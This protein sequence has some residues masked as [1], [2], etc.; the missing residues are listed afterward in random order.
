MTLRLTSAG[1]VLALAT[2]ALV[3]FNA[4]AADQLLFGTVKSAAGEALGGV[5][6]S[7]K[8]DGA[9]AK[10]AAPAE[11]SAAPQASPAD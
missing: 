1:A 9:N 3:P 6:V 7:A 11:R 4:R 2:T 5:T 10:Q 8:A